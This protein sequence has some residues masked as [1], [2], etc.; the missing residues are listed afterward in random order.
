MTKMSDM[1]KPSLL[2]AFPARWKS[3]KVLSMDS[4]VYFRIQRPANDT[5]L[6]SAPRLLRH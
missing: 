6:L 3:L 4:T 5:W 1:R 2:Q